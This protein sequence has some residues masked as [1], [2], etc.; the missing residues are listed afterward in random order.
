[1]IV[2]NIFYGWKFVGKSVLIVEY[3]QK[4]ERFMKIYLLLYMLSFNG[5]SQNRLVV[6]IGKSIANSFPFFFSLSYSFFFP[7][8]CI[9][10]WFCFNTENA[11]SCI[12]ITLRSSKYK[13]E[14]HSNSLVYCVCQFWYQINIYI[15][16]LIK[17]IIQT[18]HNI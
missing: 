18:I 5:L 16:I 2:A 10:S 6:E 14:N 8:Y 4:W 11:K 12:I 17:S 15:Y 3:L 13:G 7:C 1:M 9:I